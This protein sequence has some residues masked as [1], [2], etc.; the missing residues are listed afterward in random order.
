MDINHIIA[1]KNKTMKVLSKK[2][3]ELSKMN[4]TLKIWDN[5]KGFIQSINKNLA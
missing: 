2:N 1:A 3:L 5:Q 4:K